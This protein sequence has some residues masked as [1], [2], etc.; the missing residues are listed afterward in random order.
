ME[1]TKQTMQV[2]D[3]IRKEHFYKHSI[4]DV[5]KAISDEKQISEWFIQADFKAEVGY[6]YKFTRE[7]TIINGEVLEA[8]PV[9]T[10]VYTWIIGGTDTPT[11]VKWTL[12]EKDKGTL[13]VI[14]HS[15]IKNYPG[16]S[17]VQMFSSFSGGWDSCIVE[18][19]KFLSN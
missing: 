16:E 15:G 12:E 7:S 14:E 9:H 1:A 10:L 11:T 3:L 17:A 4:N 2:E 6:Q 19:E 18:L 8:N 13:L 5:W